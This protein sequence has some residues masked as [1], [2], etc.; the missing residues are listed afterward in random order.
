MEEKVRRQHNE[1]TIL[2]ER[3]KTPEIKSCQLDDYKQIK[4][5]RYK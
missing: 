2:R 5:P 3:D 1:D 4:N